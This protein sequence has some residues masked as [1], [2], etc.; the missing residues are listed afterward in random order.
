M[1]GEMAERAPS[2]N[3]QIRIASGLTILVALWLI[4]SP[5]ILGT[6]G[7]R[8][9]GINDA[10]VGFIV[11][12]LAAARFAGAA[13]LWQTWWVIPF[14]VWTIISPWVYG[15]AT[16]SP[17]LRYDSLAIGIALIALSMWSALTTLNEESARILISS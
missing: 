9:A 7:A 10:I 6:G 11:V 4:A 16:A 2:G 8:W 13:T 12:L 15:F 5:W 17:A 1:T 14:A 3:A